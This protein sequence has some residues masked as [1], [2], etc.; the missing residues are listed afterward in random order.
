M[1]KEKPPAREQITLRLPIKLYNELQREA[2]SMGLDIKS[3]IVFAL[4]E[5]V[6]ADPK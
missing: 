4:W 5:F 1:Q 3:I 2:E 6:N